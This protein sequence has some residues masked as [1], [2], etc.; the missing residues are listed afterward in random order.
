MT[1][2]AL[3]KNHYYTLSI[4]KESLLHSYHL[5]LMCDIQNLQLVHKFYQHHMLN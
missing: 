4:G 5:L 3:G 2:L 1:F